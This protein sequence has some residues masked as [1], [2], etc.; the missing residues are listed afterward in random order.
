MLYTESVHIAL[1]APRT[2]PCWE[3]VYVPYA[4]TG[5]KLMWADAFFFSVVRT[6]WL[7]C[8]SMRV[9]REGHA[10]ALVDEELTATR[11]NYRYMY[12]YIYVYM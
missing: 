8:M 11:D 9:S 10:H 2:R 4:L 1:H 12:M 5:N 3:P 7:H 6:P